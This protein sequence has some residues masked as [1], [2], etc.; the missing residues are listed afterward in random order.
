MDVVNRPCS[1]SIESSN[2]FSVGLFSKWRWGCSFWFLE[3]K[4]GKKCCKIVERSSKGRCVVVPSLSCGS[5]CVSSKWEVVHI[6][7]IVV[8]LLEPRPN[9]DPLVSNDR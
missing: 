3:K 5:C 1:K 9:Y 6:D 7:L 2:R 8:G 4:G